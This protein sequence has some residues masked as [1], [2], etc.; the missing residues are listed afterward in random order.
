MTQWLPLDLETEYFLLSLKANKMIFLNQSKMM[1][2][3]DK[4]YRVRHGMRKIKVK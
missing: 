2:G 1:I 3:K 4:R